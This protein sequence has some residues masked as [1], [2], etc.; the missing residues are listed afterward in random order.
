MKRAHQKRQTLRR[1]LLMG[2]FPV[3]I[4]LCMC[5]NVAAISRPTIN[6]DPPSAF[7]DFSTLSMFAGTSFA[8]SPSTITTQNEFFP[9]VPSSV[10]QQVPNRD[11]YYQWLGKT[12]QLSASTIITSS[13]PL[14]Y[15][16]LYF[17]SPLFLY[18]GEY[19][20]F[21]IKI[22]EIGFYSSTGVKIADANY[23]TVADYALVYFYESLTSATDVQGNQWQCFQFGPAYSD[24]YMNGITLYTEGGYD[25]LPLDTY[26]VVVNLEFGPILY[27]TAITGDNSDDSDDYYSELTRLEIAIQ[28]GNA[29]GQLLK[30]FLM[31]TDSS[32]VPPEF[33]EIPRF[34]L[35]S[36]IRNDEALDR[37]DDALDSFLDDID[38][39]EVSN[40]VD[41]IQF[42]FNQI[43]Q[44]GEVAVLTG[45]TI[46]ISIFRAVMGR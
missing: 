10:M 9:S 34:D 44:F 20:Q 13:V 41:F 36:M 2:T 33:G 25:T 12:V 28:Q 26:T 5:F 27:G 6:M 3:L 1:F 46:V 11:Y 18:E 38:T 37:A 43:F 14:Q 4:S 24:Q 42:A 29:I 31:G 45:G 21:W 22:N 23:F 39:S 19:L 17:D 30:D 40:C 8:M 35:D 7:F 16:S 32:Y 15:I